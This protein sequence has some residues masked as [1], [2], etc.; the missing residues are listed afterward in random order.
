MARA[1][2]M[3]KVDKKWQA[4]SDARTLMEAGVIKTD[5]KRLIAASNA[6]KIMRKE[7]QDEARAMAKVAALKKKGQKT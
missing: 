6:A 7:K 5:S 1:V 3:T 4:E 2:A